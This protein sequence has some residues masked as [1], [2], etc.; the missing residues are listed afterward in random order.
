MT[1][2]LSKRNSKRSGFHIAQMLMA[3]TCGAV[4]MADANAGIAAAADEIPAPADH[5]Y[6]GLIE[7]K[8]D[9][10]NFDQK[11]FQVHEHIPARSG[12]LTLL[13]PQW[14]P[15]THSPTGPLPQLAGLMIKAGRNTLEWKRDPVNMYAFHIDVP[16]G[17]DAIDVD[18][19]FLSPVESGGGRITAT[20]E[21]IGVQWN[22]VTLYPAGYYSSDIRVQPSLILPNG[23]KYGS[24]LVQDK[25]TGQTV[26]FKT[27]SLEELVDSPL[28][29]GKYFERVDLDPGA[30]VPVYLDVVA[31][32]PQ[33]LVIKPE[34]LAAHKA[35]VQQ[36]YKLFGSAHYDHY[37]F[38]MSLSDEFSGIGLEHHQSSENGF[39][40]GYFTEWDK[41][42]YAHDTLPHEFTHSWDGKFR[43]PAD[44]WTPNF[45]V[46]MQNS[47]LWVYEGQTEYWGCVLAARA[48]LRTAEQARDDFAMVAAGFDLRAGRSWRSL[49][50]TTNEPIVSYR[51]APAWVSWQRTADYYKESQLVWLDVDTRI[52]ELS[53]GQHSLNDFARAFFGVQNGVHVPLTYTFD[54]VVATLNAVQ[55]Y[56]WAKFLREHL[57]GHASSAPKDGLARAGWK[58][59][60]TDERSASFKDYEEQTHGPDLTF[61]IGMAIG[62]EGKIDNVIWDGI[63]FKQGLTVGTTVVA[64]NGRSYKPELLT[65]A[66][67]AAKTD[68]QPIELLLKRGDRY[69][70]AY[71]DY[72]GGLKYPHLVRIDGT[73][74]RLS[75]ILGPL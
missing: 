19:Q 10:T 63:A 45:N 65:E 42:V 38:L 68:K 5:P 61:S 17:A 28:F 55:P 21:I 73:A 35:L 53:S 49:Q 9:A 62:K 1:L 66:I 52:R 22:T 50:D 58:L 69:H 7:L 23:W 59:V 70:T 60:Y 18:F 71:I 8:V 15:G 31:D 67:T 2:I 11:I 40:P 29:A 24:A 37:D 47:L 13:Y 16:A 51:H 54:D 56:D 30:K 27:V 33:D 36:A 4:A 48:G 20:S 6:P 46:P 14:L 26:Q 75:D 74:D 34:Q 39:K 25:Q 64:V 72:H 41:A 43:R 3:L 44:L 57:D 32:R 12:R